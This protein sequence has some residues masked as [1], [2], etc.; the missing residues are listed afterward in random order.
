MIAGGP[1]PILESPVT[2][3]PDPALRAQLVASVAPMPNG[4]YVVA[5]YFLAENLTSS[6][7]DDSAKIY[8]LNADG[9]PTAD[10]LT[11]VLGRDL[12]AGS[13]FTL[14]FTTAAAT[15]ALDHVSFY[16]DGVVVATFDAGGNIVST[17]S[18]PNVSTLEIKIQ[19]LPSTDGS[20]VIGTGTVKL[21]L[22]GK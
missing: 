22:I 19:L 7:S 6:D 1:D 13:T 14:S 21:K 20:Y 16:A 5:T 9:S 4:R 12:A 3:Q 15:T 2:F 17:T 10:L 18:V 11:P 8:R